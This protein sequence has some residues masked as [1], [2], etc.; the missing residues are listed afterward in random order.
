MKLF[1]SIL[2]ATLFLVSGSISTAGAPSFPGLPDL[3]T[4]LLGPDIT[5]EEI[6]KQ[7]EYREK[8]EEF[9]KKLKAWWW[10]KHK[11]KPIPYVTVKGQK[12]KLPGK[13]LKAYLKAAEEKKLKEAW[14]K[15]EKSLK[16]GSFL[17]KG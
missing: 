15:V 11:A 12:V 16:S 8:L 17:K 7:I 1:A 4:E 10:A 2:A 13:F 14:A 5:Q 3:G 9:G 6:Q